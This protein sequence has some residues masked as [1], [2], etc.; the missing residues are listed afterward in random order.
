MPLARGRRRPVG[1]AAEA[2]QSAESIRKFRSMPGE[3][4]EGYELPT[5]SLQI[6]HEAMADAYAEKAES[7]D[8]G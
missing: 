1:Y 2:V 5:P 6:G 7:L 3:F 8:A 4:T